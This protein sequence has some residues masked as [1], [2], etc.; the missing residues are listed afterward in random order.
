[1]DNFEQSSKKGLVARAGDAATG[2][3]YGTRTA[4]TPSTK[5]KNRLDVRRALFVCH[6]PVFGGPHNWGMRLNAA[7]APRG[8][9]VLVLLPDEP[10][11]AAE[12]VRAAGSTVFQIPLHRTRKSV[13]P[14]KHLAYLVTLPREVAAIRRLLREQR[15]DV[16]MTGGYTNPHEAIAA[17]LENIPIVWQVAN[18]HSVALLR[19]LIMRM[20]ERF[21]DAIMFTGENLQR[22]YLGERKPSV[23][24]FPFY[25]PVDTKLF[26]PNELSREEVRKEFNIPMDAPVIGSVAN[27]NSQK[28]LEYW[29]RAAVLIFQQEP[30]TYF[31]W[32]GARSETNRTYAA[33]LEKEIGR[34]G[35][36]PEQ[37]ILAGPRMDTHRYLAAMDVKMLSSRYEGVATTSL[38]ALAVG[39]PVVATDV[40]GMA[41]AVR[42]G[43]TGFVVP[44]ANPAE[45]AAAALRLIQ[46]PE[47][48]RAMGEEARR[49]AVRRFDLS[50][51]AETHR[52]ALES[53]I[54]HRLRLRNAKA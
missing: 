51:C 20:I 2:D 11:N 21:A 42:N 50:I 16:V 34:S 35:I 17:R 12:R 28:G 41:E 43:Q 14:R 33:N 31:L 23:E 47:M 46:D 52:C 36:P 37:F 32:I 22:T 10:G 26:R 5:E 4:S 38:E 29:I 44:P 25:P 54:A 18:L 7:L 9:E 6:Y 39:V 30:A 49:D 53:A 8:W 45:L 24:V 15:I 13:D 40:A 19:P 1:M 48:R 3:D 27:L